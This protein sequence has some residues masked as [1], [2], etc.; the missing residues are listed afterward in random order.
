MLHESEAAAG[1]RGIDIGG[2]GG[3][4]TTLELADRGAAVWG[5]DVSERMLAHAKSRAVG[6]K[7]VRF[8]CADASTW[9]LAGSRARDR[10]LPLHPPL[11]LQLL[12][13]LPLQLLLL[14]DAYA[15]DLHGV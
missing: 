8:S 9:R 6:R 5:L 4:S 10:W 3:G 14:L 7:D 13:Q 2:G 12:L 1:E 15:A 11:V